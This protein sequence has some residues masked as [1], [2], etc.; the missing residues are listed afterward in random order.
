VTELLVGGLTGLFA[1]VAGLN[2]AL[3]RRPRPGVP[4]FTALIPARNEAG[5]IGALV[6]ALVAQAVPVIVFDDES[7]DG[8]AEEAADAGAT[9]L[10]GGPLPE[11]WV[12]KNRACHHLALAAAEASPHDW[13]V[14]LDADVEPSPDFAARLG[15]L[16]SDVGP[17]CP[18]IT[19]FPRMA[20]GAGLEPVALGW[21]PLVL[22]A[23]AP[24]GLVSRIGRGHT[25][26]TNGQIVAWR[27]ST[28]LDQMPHE[29]VRGQVLEDVGIGRLLARRGVRVEVADLSRCLSVRMYATAR[30]AVDGMSKNS[31]QIT[32]S[33]TGSVLLATFFLVWGLAWVLWPPALGLLILTKW[34]TDRVVRG[35]LWAL[36]LVP[37]SLAV[38]ALSVLRSL[39]WHRRGAVRWKGRTY[40][41]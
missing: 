20:P 30:E 35:P 25:R 23:T 17:R 11:G 29:A 9:V 38:G 22:L 31:H 18:V 28:Y 34:F 21:V 41:P 6:R 37:L 19:G 26:F 10:R 40:S 4:K 2:W 13:W 32:G 3:M 36:P 5:K 27:G 7:D 14:F 8:T 33:V 39:V 12:G 24:F 15:G 16:I 1:L